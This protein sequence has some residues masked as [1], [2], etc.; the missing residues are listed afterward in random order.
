MMR[1]R[2]V[3]DR[4]AF[5]LERML[6]KKGCRLLGSRRNIDI[7]LTGAIARFFIRNWRVVQH[8]VAYISLT[9]MGLVD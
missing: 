5:R 8:V 3:R 9:A 1:I 4:S 2:E 7:Y 6:A